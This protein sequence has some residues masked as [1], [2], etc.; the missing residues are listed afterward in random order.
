MAHIQCGMSLW[1]IDLWDVDGF[2]PGSNIDGYYL[3]KYRVDL[4]HVPQYVIL[5][6][7]NIITKRYST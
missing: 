7:W 6:M 5:C 4:H 3:Y 2:L 1:S